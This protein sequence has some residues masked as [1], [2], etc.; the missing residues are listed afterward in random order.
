MLHFEKLDT[1]TAQNQN[2]EYTPKMSPMTTL[3]STKS[4]NTAEISTK[5]NLFIKKTSE[6]DPPQ[7]QLKISEII[8]K[9]KNQWKT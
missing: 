4:K 3:K 1:K 7:N 2:S 6:P 5:L 9:K 8:T